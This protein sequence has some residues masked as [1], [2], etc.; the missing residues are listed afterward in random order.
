MGGGVAAGA[1][2]LEPTH[3]IGRLLTAHCT[4]TPMSPDL[5]KRLAQQAEHFNQEQADI[6]RRARDFEK[7]VAEGNQRGFG[8]LL[9]GLPPLSATVPI[10]R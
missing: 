9:P 4:L 10:Q 1:I 3:A 2:S 7:Q 5:A 8:V 6:E